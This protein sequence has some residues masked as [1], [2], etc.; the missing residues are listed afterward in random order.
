MKLILIVFIF[1]STISA[2]DMFWVESVSAD[3]IQIKNKKPKKLLKSKRTNSI[4][5]KSNAKNKNTTLTIKKQKFDKPNKFPKLIM[6]SSGSIEFFK[7]STFRLKVDSALYN[8][9]NGKNIDK[10]EKGTSFTSNIKSNDWIKI[11]G[12]FVKYRWKKSKK[13]IWIKKQQVVKR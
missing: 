3:M 6:K 2:E 13:D 5:L 4:I 11:T 10:W 1:I 8:N 7:A 12:Y 9:P